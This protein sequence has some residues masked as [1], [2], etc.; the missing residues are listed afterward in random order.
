[1]ANATRLTRFSSET[2]VTL[3][4]LIDLDNT[5]LGN[6]MEEFLPAY[7]RALSDELS[8]F[9]EPAHLTKSLFTATQSAI[10]HQ[11]PD[12]TLEET[13][14]STF[15]PAIGS[16]RDTLRK[17][18]DRFYREVFPS[19]QRVTQRFPEA[20]ELVEAG[21]RRGY[22]IGI[23]TAPLFPRTAILH[24]LT[25]AGL[26]PDQFHFDLIPSVESFHFTKPHLGYFAEFLAQMGWPDDPVVMVG[27]DLEA[28]I[29]P[30]GLFGLATFWI[31]REKFDGECIGD[32]QHG[33]GALSDVLPWIDERLPGGLQSDYNHPQALYAILQSTP[34][35]LLTLKNSVAS[36]RWENRMN[37]D[38][39]NL[40]E[41][42]CHLRDVDA[43]VNIPRI[44]KLIDENNPFLPGVDTDRWADERKY[45]SQNGSNALTD[46]VNARLE[47]LSLFEQLSEQDWQRRARHAILGP[48]TLQEI[49]AI[50]ASH[51]RLHIQQ[52]HR[53][54]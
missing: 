25:W 16:D 54:L 17:P 46:F 48:T 20:V 24:R 11:R 32:P 41:I 36:E 22:R 52:I 30:A 35:A 28:D 39:W 7:T 18:I 44:N 2:P 51:D 27:D 42:I 34:A 49:A 40:T 21:L 19:L 14:N 33:S 29:T 43:D 8:N 38:E 45:S 50:I 13:F 23:A 26:N 10:N 53:Q 15:Y 5:L 37:A 1:V 4:L 3:T 6:R 12:H 9:D 31:T 47:L